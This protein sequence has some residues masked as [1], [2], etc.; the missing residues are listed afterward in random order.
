[1]RR[2]SRDGRR[3]PARIGRRGLLRSS[4]VGLARLAGAAAV[5]AA[6]G[7]RPARGSAAH[8]EL[9]IDGVICPIDSGDGFDHPHELTTTIGE[10]DTSEFDP[11][12]F[13]QLFD[14]GAVGTLPDGRTLRE[15][16]LVAVDKEI[17][18]A[19]GV[20]VPAWT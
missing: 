5:T 6:D 3:A 12:V 4:A 8:S 16:T 17:E 2:F 15:Y 9:Q 14:R 19:P 7:N 1:M 11:M 20:L 10:V 18:I 13:L